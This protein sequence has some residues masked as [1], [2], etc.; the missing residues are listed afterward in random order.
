VATQ[1]IGAARELWQQAGERYS[2]AL[3]IK[4]DMH[5]AANNWGTVLEHEAQ[6]VATQDLGAARVLWQQAGEKYA[7]ALTIKPDT[8]HAVNSWSTGLIH[9]AQALLA[10]QLKD[11][12]DQVLTRVVTLLEQHIA[13]WPDARGQLAYNLA[14]V[15]SLQGRA[16]DAVAQLEAALQAE[17]LPDPDHWLTD[18]DLDPIR[19]SAE[20]LA[21]VAQHFPNPIPTDT[22]A[23]KGT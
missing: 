7:Q 2:Q 19:T 15:Y 17:Q 10:H 9:E 23:S 5:E 1:D 14:C 3:K 11:D 8:H 12:A 13:T 18:S 4:P 16:A 6:A 22:N 20:Y 21:W